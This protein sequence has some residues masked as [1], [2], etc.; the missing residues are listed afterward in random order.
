MTSASDA[1]RTYMTRIDDAA[2]PYRDAAAGGRW[3]CDGATRWGTYASR[4]YNQDCAACAPCT[5]DRM[6]VRDAVRDNWVGGCCAG[7][8]YGSGGGKKWPWADGVATNSLAGAQFMAR[9]KDPNPFAPPLEERYA[10][11][12]LAELGSP[13]PVYFL[14][15]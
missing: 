3:S 7:E 12:N 13:A 6:A 8:T 15:R 10:S 2:S 1:Q 4:Q 14:A 5:T 11:T 9:S